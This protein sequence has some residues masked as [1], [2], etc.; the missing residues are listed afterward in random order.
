M[1]KE[2]RRLWFVRGSRKALISC[3]ETDELI[4]V[5]DSRLPGT[6]VL[7]AKRKIS[8]AVAMVSIMRSSC[9]FH[10]GLYRSDL[11]L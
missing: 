6:E 11:I 10:P 8:I 3:L 9:L 1:L 4:G 5:P 7:S 2:R